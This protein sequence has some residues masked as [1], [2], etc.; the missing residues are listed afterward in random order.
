MKTMTVASFKKFAM[1]AVV[2]AALTVGTQSCS[3]GKVEADK[4]DN[5]TTTL[6]EYEKGQFRIEDETVTK[7]SVSRTII[8]YMDGTEKELGQGEVKAL[9]ADNDPLEGYAGAETQPAYYNNHS[10][11]IWFLLY[12]SN[13]GYH[14]GRPHTMGIHRGFYSPTAYTRATA[15]QTSVVKSRTTTRVAATS[16]KAPVK[17]SS[18]YG[19]SSSRGY[20]GGSSRGGSFGG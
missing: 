18:S 16:S 12:W 1:Y 10:G 19:R 13:M 7:D 4:Y 8:Q 3:D 11:D 5:V 9:F 20:S 14:L 2:A 15:T 6:V 17:S